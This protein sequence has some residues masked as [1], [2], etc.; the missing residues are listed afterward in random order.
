MNVYKSKDYKECIEALNHNLAL[1]PFKDD[2]FRPRV[3]TNR[4]LVKFYIEQGYLL[5][6]Y[7]TQENMD[8]LILQGDDPK[9]RERAKYLLGE[10]YPKSL[11][12]EQGAVI[13][14]YINEGGKSGN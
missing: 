5:S 8:T 10:L 11:I 6:F 7:M 14:C 4:N 9:D 13:Y 1:V 3:L 2:N 12:K